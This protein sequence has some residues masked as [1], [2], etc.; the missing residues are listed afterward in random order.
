MLYLLIP[1]MS[2][3]NRFRGAGWVPNNK[4]LAWPL[5]GALLFLI[6]G[7]WLWTLIVTVGVF[8]EF[9]LSWGQ[10]LSMNRRG[11]TPNDGTTGFPWSGD[12]PRW[13]IWYVKLL[14]KLSGGDDYRGTFLRHL[15]ITPMFVGLVYFGFL[16]PLVAVG[17]TLLHA[18]LYT[19]AFHFAGLWTDTP[20]RGDIIGP[21]EWLGG[22]TFGFILILTRVL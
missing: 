21:G 22:L 3:W 5:L 15:F 16:E 6:T 7:D 20:G 1:A 12:D 17:L 18:F 10:F 4:Y 19:V 9:K 8:P 13:N 14:H 2:F 11:S